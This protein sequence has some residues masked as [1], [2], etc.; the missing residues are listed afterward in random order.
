MKEKIQMSK[1]NGF[2]IIDNKRTPIIALVILI[3]VAATASA[4]TYDSLPGDDH[5]QPWHIV[6]DE[7]IYDQKTDQYIAKGNATI[8]REGK[9]L[10]ADFVRFNY[11]TMEAFAMG[12]VVMTAG[13]DILISSSMEMDLGAEIGTIYNGTIF[14]KANNVYIKG[15]K[16]QKLGKNSYAADKVSITTCDGDSPAWK[17]TGKNLKV[18]IEGYAFV[19]HAALWAKKV[20]V[21]YTPF[22]VFPA[23]LKRQSGLLP[24]QIGYSD[25]KWEEYIQ[26][27]YWAIN[28]SSDMTFYAHHMGRRGDKTGLEYRYVLDDKSKGALMYDFFND[29]KVDDA[30]LN[31]NSDWGYEDDNELRPNSD[32]YWF[33]MKHDQS[34]PFDFFAKIDLDFVS[35]QDYLHEFRDGYTGFDETEKYFNNNFGRELDD[36]DDPVRVNKLNLNRSWSKY[37]LNAEVRWYDN[38]INRRWKDQDTTLQ[39]LPLIEF[40]GS[41]QQLPITP[42]YFDLDSEY[43]YF[44]RKDIATDQ[45]TG[46]RV[47][48]HPRFYLPLRFKNYFSFEP[49]FGLRETAW[50]IDKYEDDS[51]KADRTLS[52]EIYDIKLDLS[53]EIFKAYHI[54]GKKIDG[55]KHIVTPQ[56]IYDYIPEQ[57]QDK[58]PSFDLI[59]RIEK[60]NLLTYS[61]TNT[62]ISKLIDSRKGDSGKG[63]KSRDD[64]NDER[65]SYNYYQFCRFKL[66]QTYD[67]N[68]AKENDPE[69]FS[70]VNG[71]LEFVPGRY[72]SIDA[73]ATW[74]PYE[75]D[76]LS[77]NIAVTI[78]DNREDRLL[79]EY[80]YTRDLVES[81]YTNLLLKISD[82]L[83]VY[84]DYERNMYDGK[85][86]RTGAGFLYKA[87]CWSIDCSY[88][89]EGGDRQYTFMVNLYGLGEFGKSMA[90]GRI[91]KPF[92]EN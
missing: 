70:S 76:F 91:E 23:K 89:D 82:G 16:I 44:F 64:E 50:Y 56:I 90:G 22:L 2:K 4:E 49:S 45:T 72:F 11:K 41:R 25:R 33:R 31:S 30:A 53:S 32:R 61:I 62:L 65:V 3:T 46:H 68:K 35:D 14:L 48:L 21:L 13:E 40:D 71:E 47:D 60:Q 55:I 29:R 7:I 59:D 58:Y 9:K 67:I 52:R 17:I 66:E 86:I 75:T 26:P 54:K 88:E 19:N 15:D 10:T 12:H 74:S 63:E 38:V 37:S 81:I 79:V 34:M 78:L 18:T 42:F 27:F 24:P 39:K 77:H 83:S 87:Q 57:N 6:A 73:D 92:E 8:T 5:A 1:L 84:T 20:P 85:N 28:E 36:Y 69:P 51:T 43:T 80:R